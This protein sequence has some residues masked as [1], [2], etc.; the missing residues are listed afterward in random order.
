MR[1]PCCAADDRTLGLCTD[2]AVYVQLLGARIVPASTHL[3]AYS[4][5]CGGRTARMLL[6]GMHEH[7][8]EPEPPPHGQQRAPLLRV[9]APNFENAYASDRQAH[10]AMQ[11]VLCKVQRCRQLMQAYM[12]SLG[13]T[14]RV[15]HVAH[16]SLDPRAVLQ[17]SSSRGG[18]GVGGAGG[19][20]RRR[21]GSSSSD[22]SLQP[23]AA[24]AEH[25]GFLHVRGKST[26]KHTRQLLDCWMQHPE[27]PQLTVVGPMPNEHVSGRV[28]AC[29][30][31]LSSPLCRRQPPPA[32][33]GA[34]QLLRRC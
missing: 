5:A 22:G 4:A 2:A 17:L 18:S 25:P 14:A 16:T 32:A 19:G 28:L 9:W 13:S 1:V 33:P 3:D 12:A 20:A 24:A 7:W 23:A 11:L 15:M 31:C 10:A 8:A 27:W 6:E 30:H 34:V 21:G 29:L 26:L